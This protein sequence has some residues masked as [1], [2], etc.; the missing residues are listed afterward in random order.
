MVRQGV[1][2]IKIAEERP[3]TV[4]IKEKDVFLDGQISSSTSFFLSDGEAIK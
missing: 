3:S 4:F 1:F 2:N